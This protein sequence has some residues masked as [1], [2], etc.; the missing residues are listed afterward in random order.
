MR[1][2]I[3]VFAVIFALSAV[4]CTSCS[5][6]DEPKAPSLV[7]NWIGTQGSSTVEFTFTSS[8]FTWKRDGEVILNAPYTCNE[9]ASNG[10]YIQWAEGLLED[11]YA[12]YYSI[13]GNTMNIN[14]AN[15]SILRDIPQ[16]LT[17][18]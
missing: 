9:S 15:G 10:K 1:R 14:G 3:F 11:G 8:N 13:D 2:I 16:T 18:Q 17:R 4:L 5:S 7:G 6:D 12:I